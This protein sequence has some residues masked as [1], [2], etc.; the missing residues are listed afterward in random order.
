M[1]VLDQQGQSSLV[2]LGLTRLDGSRGDS[3]V[4]PDSPRKPAT[5]FRVA[6]DTV[7]LADLPELLTC[8]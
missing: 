1:G 3:L 4:E 5:S 8:E 2:A 7:L 6:L